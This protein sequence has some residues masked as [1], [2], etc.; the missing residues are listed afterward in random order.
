MFPIKNGLKQG[1]PFSPFLFN[2][3]FE[4]VIRRVQVIQDDTKFNGTHQLLVYADDVNVL[5]G[6]VNT[7]RKNA[8]TSIVASKESGLEVNANQT[9]YTVIS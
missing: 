8:V 5:D 2:F 7:I 9:E 1:G 4:Y 3:T 6:S